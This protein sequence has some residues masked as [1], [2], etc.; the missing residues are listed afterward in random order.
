MIDISIYPLV[1]HNFLL[2]EQYQE[3]IIF[4]VGQANW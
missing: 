3:I 4:I 1:P 2:Q